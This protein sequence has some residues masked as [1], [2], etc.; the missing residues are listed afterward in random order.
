MLRSLK[1]AR[2]SEM[3]E[4]HFALAAPTLYALHFADPPLSGFDCAS[5][6]QGA[7]QGGRERRGGGGEGTAQLAVDASE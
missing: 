4:G 2:Y 3:N 1:Q 5:H 6:R 7:A